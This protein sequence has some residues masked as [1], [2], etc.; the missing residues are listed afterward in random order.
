[1][2]QPATLRI[3]GGAG[4]GGGPAIVAPS[5]LHSAAAERGASEDAGCEAK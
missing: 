2:I 3:A 5:R 4:R 1:M